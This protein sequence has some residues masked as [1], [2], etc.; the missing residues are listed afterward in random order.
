M[1][2]IA[3]GIYTAEPEWRGMIRTAMEAMVASAIPVK[4]PAAWFENPGFD[5]V[6]PLR[7]DATGRVAGHIATWK[8]EHIGM[9]GRVKAPKSRSGYAFFATGVLETAEGKMVNVGQI[10]LAGGH[11]SLEASVA[12]VV[13]H[14]DNT[15]SGVMDVAIGEDDHGIWVAGALRP[16]VDDVKLRTIRASSVSGDWRPINGNL[17]LVAVCAVN[18]PGFPIPQARVAG[19]A[20]V[21]LVAAGTAE[22]VD[23]IMAERASD[24]EIAAFTAALESYDTRLRLL[25]D[26][27]IGR[28]SEQREA[29]MAAVEA[30]KE[31]HAH[32]TDNSAALAAA[33][34]SRVAG[35]TDVWEDGL[36]YEL[37]IAEGVQASLRARAK[38]VTATASSSW[39]KDKREQ[40]AKRGQALPDGSYPIK[41]KTDWHKAKHAL[42]RA[43][44]RAAVVRHLRKRGRALGIPAAEY[45][46]L[47]LR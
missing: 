38:G 4:P 6:S 28:I 9:A 22:I 32:S 10:T 25:E 44:N 3:D 1:T 29:I 19:G 17:E 36:C 37:T 23:V 34:R 47:T 20:P 7:A 15:Q 30:A 27:L 11:A 33:L 40:A 46:S 31:V 18:V 39:T 21:A 14:Y 24:A 13:A 43:K 8:Q 41:D 12:D 35:D 16:D 42:G 5:K 2:D 45:Q 26:A